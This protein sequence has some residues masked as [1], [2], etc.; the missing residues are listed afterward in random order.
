M[1]ESDTENASLTVSAADDTP[2]DR[3]VIADS[4]G[5]IEDATLLVFNVEAEDDDITITDINDVAITSS[6]TTI[7]TVYLYNEDGEEIASSDVDDGLANFEDIDTTVNDGD[8]ATFTIKFDKKNIDDDD[9]FEE[10]ATVYA[11][12]D[13]SKIVAENSEGDD[14]SE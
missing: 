3:N 11:V 14:V 12:V 2:K 5:D 13:G 6:S 1:T 8:T 9:D 4:N 10:G 7:D